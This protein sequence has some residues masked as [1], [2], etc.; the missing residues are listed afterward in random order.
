MRDTIKKLSVITTVLLLAGCTGGAGEVPSTG[1]LLK[2]ELSSELMQPGGTVL[3]RTSVNNFFDNELKDAEG[4]LIRSF[5]QLNIDPQQ[6]QT[7]GTVQANPNATAR[8][9]W[10][11]DVRESAL[12]GTEFTNK[13][14]LCFQYEQTA[15]HELAVV[16]SFEIESAVNSGT[17][18]G[19]LKI[20]FSGLETPYIKNEQ[21]NSKIPIS[22]SI[23]N[24]YVG[25]VADNTGVDMSKDTIPYVDF[26]EVRIYD[27]NVSPHFAVIDD[28]TNPSSCETGFKDC[29][30]CE[31]GHSSTD[32]E[33]YI[34]C[35]ADDLSVFGDETFLGTKLD[36]ITEAPYPEELIQTVEVTATYYY[37]VESSEFTLTVF[38]PGG[39]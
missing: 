5:G 30:V 29:F 15:W 14:R 39:N 38:T 34:K 33:S 20:S 9:Q 31:P 8:T 1:I 17:E 22:I 12:D 2:N 24:N 21:V 11:L 4:K 16:N 6:K 28:F 23:K 37:C 36:V 35:T 19:P 25:Y 10:T 3:L 32:G 18:T 7:I 13:V 27:D 26:I